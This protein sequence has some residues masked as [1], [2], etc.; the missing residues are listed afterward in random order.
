MPNVEI[1]A[2]SLDEL[3]KKKRDEQ[4]TLKTKRKKIQN[5]YLA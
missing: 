4:N 3:T 5:G 2:T 1:T